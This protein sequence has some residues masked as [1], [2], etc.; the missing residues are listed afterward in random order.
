MRDILLDTG[1]IVATLDPRDQWHKAC[2]GLV[3]RYADRCVT[4][5]AVV[6]EACH[7]AG[8]AGRSGA[9]AIDFLL[10]LGVPVLSIE[11]AGLRACARLMDRYA[12]VP[13][14]FA[15]ATL[16]AMAE[17][18]RITRV[19]TLDVRGFRAYRTADGSALEVVRGR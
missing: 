5:E 13:M 9:V 1:P 11:T 8:R 12:N 3:A 18:L 6:T 14:D 7:L 4:S 15:D 17:A 19:A 2:V 16:V 10:D